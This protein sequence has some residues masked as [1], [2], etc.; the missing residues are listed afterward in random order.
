MVVVA[1]AQTV[2]LDSAGRGG[3]SAFSFRRPSGAGRAGQPQ[4]RP[5]GLLL[6]QNGGRRNPWPR[7]LKFSKNRGVFC[8]V[9][10]YEMAFSEVVSSVW[11]PCLFS[12]NLKALFKRNEAISSCLLDE[13]LTTF[14]GHFGSLGQGFLRPPF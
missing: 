4:P 1:G 9:T 13:I 8:H 6:V 11:R 10:H 2:K 5:Q 14:L 12:C 3:L 7:L